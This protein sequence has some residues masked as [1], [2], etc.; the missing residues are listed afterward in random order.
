[1]TPLEEIVMRSLLDMHPSV[2]M[3]MLTAFRAS[4]G[5]MV[6]VADPDGSFHY[7]WL[8]GSLYSGSD[9][10]MAVVNY[11]CAMWKQMLG[12]RVVPKC[13]YQVELSPEK[14]GHLL[15]SVRFRTCVARRGDLP[16]TSLDIWIR[17]QLPETP[18]P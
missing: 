14:R 9:I 13:V 1:M 17:G 8:V 4:L 16:E 7:D 15:V 2:S 5:H 6:K 18:M 3:R 11:Q 10:G 12:V